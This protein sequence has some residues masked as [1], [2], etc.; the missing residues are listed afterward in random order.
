MQS[1]EPPE[2]CPGAHFRIQSTQDEATSSVAV[3]F[4]AESEPVLGSLFQALHWPTLGLKLWMQAYA[5]LCLY[6]C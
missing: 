3:R 6:G 5:M 4:Y 1:V 2:L